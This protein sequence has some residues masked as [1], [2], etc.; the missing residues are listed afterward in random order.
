MTTTAV[1][2]V[3][4]QGLGS[5]PTSLET[6]NALVS[7]IRAFNAALGTRAANFSATMINGPEDADDNGLD[8]DRYLPFTGGV[9][10]MVYFTVTYDPQKLPANKLAEWETKYDLKV[11]GR[12]VSSLDIVALDPPPSSRGQV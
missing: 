5:E 3:S 2:Y 9:F 1:G 8:P 6:L 12:T 7:E 4:L 10:P 11:T